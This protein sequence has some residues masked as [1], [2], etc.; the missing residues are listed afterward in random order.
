MS[1]VLKPG[2]AC[3]HLLGM[4]LTGARKGAGWKITEVVVR[5][6]NASGGN[7]SIGYHAVHKDGTPAF[8]KATDIGLLTRMRVGDHLT[9]MRQALHEHQFER[10]ILEICRGNNLDRIVHAIDHGELEVTHNGVRDIVLFIMFE[11]AEGG[12]VRRQ[13]DREKRAT[14][15]WTLHAAHNLSVAI[16]QL[17]RHYI[18]HNDVKPS[19]FLVFDEELQKLA[20]LG[21]ATS[22]E[23]NG[24]WDQVPYAGDTNYAAPEFCYRN[25]TLA[26]DRGRIAFSVRQASDLYHLGSMAFFLAT[27]EKFTPLMRTHIRPEHNPNNWRGTFQEVLPFVRDATGRALAHLDDVLP[28]REGKPTPEAENFR[29]AITQLCDPDPALRGHPHNRAGQG[30]RYGLERYI[31]QFD[32]DSKSMAVRARAE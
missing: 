25:V 18:A 27:G 32:I 7:F 4:T 23:I 15:S 16:Q 14:L 19:N 1:T 13:I 31:S 29:T 9:R 30:D 2:S 24:P 20:D 28:K 12:D 10:E 26:H 11:R 6:R 21:R 3:E 5:D 22:D 8:V 17:H